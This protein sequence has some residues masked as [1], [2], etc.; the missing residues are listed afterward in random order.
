[1]KPLFRIALF[2][3]L[4]TGIVWAEERRVDY[5]GYTLWL[6]CE[7]R[8]AVR[9]EYT[10]GRDTGDEKRK[11]YK[12]YRLDPSIGDCQQLGTRSY[13]KESNQKYQ[14]DISFR[15]IAWTTHLNL[16]AMKIRW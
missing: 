2:L 9:F 6:D 13:W 11:D 1:M 10:I 5:E 7:K 12:K 8:S 3:P 4:L 14:K 15:S 16:Q